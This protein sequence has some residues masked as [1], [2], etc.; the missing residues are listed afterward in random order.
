MKKYLLIFVILIVTINV[1]ANIKLPSLVGDN[2]VLQR[3]KPLT[4]WGWADAGEK[5]SIS[6]LEK[7]YT[8]TTLPNGKW[9]IRI[10]QQ[11]AGGPYSMVIA[12][13]N[14]ITLN[15]L[16]IGDVWICG[17]QSNMEVTMSNALNPDKE[18]AAANNPNIHLF[19][20]AHATTALR[21]EDVKGQWLE[22][23]PINIKNFSA[24]AYYFARDIQPKIEVPVG[25]IECGYGGTA[26]EAWISPEGLV[27]DPVFAERAA[28]LKSLDL[29]DL[30]KNSETYYY[31]WVAPIDKS[32][33]AYTN[34]TFDWAKQPHPEWPVTYFPSTFE[35]TPHIELKD[36]IIWVTKSIDLTEADIAA[37]C[38][39][40]L[41]VIEDDGLAFV[42]GTMVGSTRN[43]KTNTV[44]EVDKAILR[45]GDNHITVRIIDFDGGA[46]MYGK[47]GIPL[48]LKTPDRIVSLNGSWNYK[49]SLDTTFAIS[50]R[51]RFNPEHV[52]SVLFNG[53]IA[54]L[55]PYAFTGF[56]WY[57]GEANTLKAYHYRSLFKKLINDWR[58]QF[59]APDAPFL[60]VQLA[61]YKSPAL[62]PGES[63]WAE[64]REAQAMALS[65]KN[66][67]MI[68]TIDIGEAYNIHPKNKQDVGKRLALQ[69]RKIVYGEKKLVAAGPVFKKVIYKRN[70]CIISF[71]NEGSGLATKD[72]GLELKEF[73]VAT[74]GK[75]QFV[76]A[77]AMINGKNSIS[78]S[79]PNGKPI[80]A[81][82]YAWAN[83]PATVN[84]INKEGLPA[85]PFR[86]DDFKGITY[87]KN[88]DSK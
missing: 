12:G 22:C 41:G 74:D 48:S 31:K 10:P 82:R 6:F 80:T 50:Y 88:F 25:L 73:A 37:N 11:K 85:Y 70:S 49:M 45:K 64:L 20:V 57:Q 72:G 26:A 67:G 87:D 40:R 5:I 42:N 15:N 34:G 59:K 69:A 63:I 54:P 19:N 46:G 33:P 23:N 18:I 29:E 13:N 53:M 75:Q 1:F 30:I 56:L 47:R 78:I 35:S 14:S 24:I 8:A 52:P 86:T 4:I 68:T 83:N 28:Q 38:S 61:N 21:A 60:F 27:G 51:K 71:T 44:Y 65:L 84:L 77:K 17:G 76:T 36:G 62:T 58:I 79:S 55:T 81:V 39:L 3:D 16:L 7:I 9:N 32:D 66:T 43:E 2:M